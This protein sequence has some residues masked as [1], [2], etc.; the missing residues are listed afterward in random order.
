[1]IECQFQPGDLYNCYGSF[2]N[3]I[4]GGAWNGPSILV[5]KEYMSN[6]EFCLVSKLANKTNLF[7]QPKL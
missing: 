4:H 5:A 1:M 6:K 2:S 7:V 3:D